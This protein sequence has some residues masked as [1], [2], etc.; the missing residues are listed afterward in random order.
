MSTQPPQYS[1]A[2]E[3]LGMLHNQR[4]LLRATA[5][6]L[7]AAQG[8]ERSTVSELTIGGLL[9]HAAAT[10]R[11][12]MDVFAERPCEFN[13]DPSQYLMPEDA[14]IDG[15]IDAHVKV[16]EDTA[17]TVAELGDLDRIVQLPAFPW[18]DDDKGDR[19]PRR[20]ILLH[21]L[22]EIAHHCGHADIIREA[23]D[24]ANTT[25]QMAQIQ[26]EG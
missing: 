9:N 18:A 6:G 14:T 23:I 25:M 8:R 16:E 7:T 15:L 21:L 1:E 11:F 4:Q 26:A 10:E 5:R 19:W 12:W 3:L 22:R 2:A 20:R 13:F 17:R 24:G